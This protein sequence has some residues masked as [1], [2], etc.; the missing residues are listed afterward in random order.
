MLGG[1]ATGINSFL[2]FLLLLVLLLL[3][4]CRSWALSPG[5][6]GG[7]FVVVRYCY[8]HASHRP[9]KLAPG[10]LFYLTG[11]LRRWRLLSLRYSGYG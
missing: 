7:G 5:V 4:R 2:A 10:L 3:L 9:I 8:I 6:W 1:G 11:C